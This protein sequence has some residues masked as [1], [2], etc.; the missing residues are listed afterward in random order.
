MSLKESIIERSLMLHKVEIMNGKVINCIGLM[1]GRHDMRRL[2]MRSQPTSRPTTA[3]SHRKNK[4][5]CRKKELVKEES[6]QS[7]GS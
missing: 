1:N 2:N 4:R 7:K 5:K 3:T 6:I